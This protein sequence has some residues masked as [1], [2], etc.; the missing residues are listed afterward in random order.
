MSL[1]E[2]K[3]DDLVEDV[4]EEQELENEELVE[5]EQVQ[6]EE[7]VEAKD[8]GEDDED[9]EEVKE[10]SDEDEDDDD[11]EEDVMEMPKTK[12]AIM[13]GV[14]DMLKK[15]NKEG[16]E[17]IYAQV[18]KVVKA[19]D[20][21]E[22]KVMSKEDVD[23]D[24]SHI[25]YSEDL[26]SLVAEEATL[27]DGF[28]AKAGIIFEAALKSKVS[29]EIERLE[30]EYVQNLEEE[31]TEIKSELVEKVDSYLNYV[32]SNWMDDNEVAVSNG[33][34]TEIAEEFMTSLQSVF[35][36]H[37]IEVPE[38][39]VDLVDELS[40]QV[41]ELEESLNKSTEDNIRLNESVSKLERAEI[42]RNAS[43]GL[44]LTEAEKLASLVEDIDFDNA[45]SFEMKV[46]VV[47]ESYFKTEGQESV[48]EAQQLAG[49]D[50]A[51]AAISDA[52]AR[53]TSAI[54][55]FNKYKS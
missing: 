7:I 35:K 6:D 52:M 18:Y 38:G 33:L 27:S 11:D 48:D 28:Q 19:P 21:E 10:D 41:T 31:V 42:V 45:E 50:E 46:N 22:P 12:A 4:S 2:I 36:E 3:K 40:E 20:V 43:S 23:V 17:K 54:S 16:M 55:K 9:E 39:K 5:D 47:K 29:K 32:V 51:P 53:Y 30:S 37:Y 34:R 49:T 25:D 24:V 44:A 26:E 15:S 8:E 14:H 13:A 1:D